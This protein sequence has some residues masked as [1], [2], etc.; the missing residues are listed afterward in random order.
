MLRLGQL[1]PQVILERLGDAHLLTFTF[2]VLGGLSLPY[3]FALLRIAGA[4]VTVAVVEP[5]RPRLEKLSQAPATVAYGLLAF[6][7]L[8]LVAVVA[9]AMAGSLWVAAGCLLLR[10]LA[11]GLGAPL[12]QAWLVQN[13]Q[14][15]TRATAMSFVGQAH[16]LGEVAGGPGVGWI[17]SRF[18]LPVAL[19]TAAILLVPAIPFYLLA[20]R[21]APEAGPAVTELEPADA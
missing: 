4:V 19:L 8:S 18:G 10:T 1:A 21:R 5:L 16:A 2:P 6:D 17:G 13:T 12:F 7:S 20:A 14:P 3:W 15:A 11:F 9:F